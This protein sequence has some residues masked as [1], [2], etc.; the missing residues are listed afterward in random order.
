MQP[1]A[2]AVAQLEERMQPIPLSQTNGNNIPLTPIVVDLKNTPKANSSSTLPSTTPKFY[3]PSNETLNVNTYSNSFPDEILH[4][5][6]CALEAQCTELSKVQED[7]RYRE[8][9]YNERK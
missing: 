8:T 7:Q 6:L 2:T 3:I 5:R 9:V 1:L 4:A